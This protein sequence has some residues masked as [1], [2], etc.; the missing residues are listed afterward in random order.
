MAE[1]ILHM[2]SFM[3]LSREKINLIISSFYSVIGWSVEKNDD[4]VPSAPLSAGSWAGILEITAEFLSSLG[5]HVGIGAKCN[6]GT[7]AW[8]T[9]TF[10]ILH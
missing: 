4:V 5:L 6:A 1:K 10:K 8:E 7:R 2:C 3:N 9:Y